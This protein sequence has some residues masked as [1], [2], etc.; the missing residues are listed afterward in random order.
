MAKTKKDVAYY[1]VPFDYGYVVMEKNETESP[2]PTVQT[3]TIPEAIDE[4]KK[5]A[6]KIQTLHKIVTKKLLETDDVQSSLYVVKKARYC[7]S[8]EIELIG[9]LCSYIPSPLYQ[10]YNFEVP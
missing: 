10:G 9:I 7:F 8:L 4:L 6:K 5:V 1:V 2:I 3:A